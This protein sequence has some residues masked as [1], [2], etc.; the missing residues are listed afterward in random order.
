M[1]PEATFYLSTYTESLPHVKTTG[2]G[3]ICC[4][5][6]YDTGALK[7]KSEP[8]HARN[9]SY[10]WL[11]R[12]RSRLYAIAEVL[13]HEGKKDGCLQV[14]DVNDNT[15][16]LQQVVS[17][18]GIGPAYCRGDDSGKNLLS[19]NYL[20]GS[21]YCYPIQDDGLLG[22]YSS[23][24]TLSGNGPN[25]TRQDAP[26]PHCIVTNSKNNRAYVADLGTDQ[27]I[28]YQFDAASGKLSRD[29][30]V[31]Y[32]FKPNSG[33]RHAWFHPNG[34]HCF[35]TLELSSELAV[36]RIEANRAPEMVA[37]SSTTQ[38][39]TEGN[40]PSEHV[41]TRDGSSIYVANRGR[42]SVGVFNFDPS[43]ET[44]RQ[45]G[46]TACGGATPR[47][48]ALC[49]EERFLIVANQDGNTVNCLRR[50]LQNGDIQL[51]EHQLKINAPCFIAFR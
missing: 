39:D 19:V 16:K 1:K 49:P 26:H 46:E 30:S 17:S 44:L 22:S 7:Y 15:I 9:P 25:K 40:H 13:D 18:S 48:L 34:K 36:L 8:V 29:E 2:P 10:L 37:I 20:A 12:T 24:D 6:N 35:V 47:H 21:V 42:D 43:N 23:C 38:Q 3:I 14:Y 5:L 32:R 27:L 11:N 45:I 28:S 33:P 50:D 51:T 41:V 31:S 4:S